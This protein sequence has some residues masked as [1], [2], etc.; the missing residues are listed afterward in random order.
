MKGETDERDSK[1]DKTMEKGRSSRE[2]VYEIVRD[3]KKERKRW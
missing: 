1:I 2:S 3:G